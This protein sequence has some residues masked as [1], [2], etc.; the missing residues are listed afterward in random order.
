MGIGQWGETLVTAY[1]GNH[2]LRLIA[3]NWRCP[4]GELDVIGYDADTLV[5]VEVRTRRGRAALE[6]ALA[7]VD[8]K[9]QARLASL[10]EHYCAANAIPDSTPVRVDVVGVAVLP[11][12][13]AHIEWVKDALDW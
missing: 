7:S 2:G 13:L 8:T 6:R 4:L 5:I 10:V 3:C 9:K 12:G 1:L 11:D